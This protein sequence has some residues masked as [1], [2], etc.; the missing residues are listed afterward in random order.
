MAEGC[1]WWLSIIVGGASYD[2]LANDRVEA[3]RSRRAVSRVLSAGAASGR[4]SLTADVTL[5]WQTFLRRSGIEHLFPT[6]QQAVGSTAPKLRTAQATGR[7][8]C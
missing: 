8:T 3:G 5:L 6:V 2:A 1:R 7:W 4:F